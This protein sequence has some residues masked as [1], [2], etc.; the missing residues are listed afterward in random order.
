[1]SFR[2][3]ARFGAAFAGIPALASGL[4]TAA[5][6]YPV[7]GGLDLQPAATEAAQHV[8]DFHT[9]LLWIITAITVF[10]MILLL[11]V[12]VRYNSKANPV[13]KKFSHNTL[14]EILWTGLPV[15]ILVFIAYKSFP[16]LYEQDVFPSDKAAASGQPVIDVKVTGRQWG[17]D[18]SYGPTKTTPNY[19]SDMIKTKEALKEG[20]IW[21]L[22]VDNPLVVPQGR[23]VRVSL[24]ATDV[25]H[26]FAVP[27]FAIKTD[28][29]PGRL[30]QQ[31]FKVD[32]PGIFYGQCSELCGM[33]HS[34]MPIEVRVLPQAEY[35]QWFRLMME[36]ADKPAGERRK[37]ARDYL[38]EVQN[39]KQ[40]NQ[41]AAAQ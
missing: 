36:P 27:A 23:Y 37:A 35:D 3:L 14:L 4:L 26:A 15:L 1:M 13:P 7:P 9:L 30:N 24:A 34:G 31:W 12:I 40:M 19:T 38:F 6:A 18:Y 17:W 20:Q 28:A 29:V 8:H 11:W 16:L 5:A 22:S 21:R 39:E 32:K 25:I 41:V 2:A 10:V 33:A